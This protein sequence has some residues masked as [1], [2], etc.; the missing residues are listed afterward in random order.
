[1]CSSGFRLDQIDPGGD[2]HE[3]LHSIRLRSQTKAEGILGLSLFVQILCVV[4]WMMHKS[5]GRFLR[6]ALG[7][8]GLDFLGWPDFAVFEDCGISASRSKLKGG[9]AVL[10]FR[11]DVRQ[12]LGLAVT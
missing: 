6:P 7:L 8:S 1:M 10:S 9:G 3:S 5:V 2:D 4:P 12:M 11:S